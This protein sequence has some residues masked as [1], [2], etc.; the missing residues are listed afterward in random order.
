MKRNLFVPTLA[1]LF[2]A[3]IGMATEKKQSGGEAK[4]QLTQCDLK[5]SGMTC[6]GC[7][8]SAEARLAKIPG[9]KSATVNLDSAEAKVDFDSTA[10]TPEKIVAAFNESGGFRAELSTRQS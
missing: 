4:L 2:L 5:V 8:R 10:T 6:G 1:V 7:A 3:G 9:V